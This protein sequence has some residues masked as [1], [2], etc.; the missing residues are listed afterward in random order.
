MALHTDRPGGSARNQWPGRV[1]GFDLLGDRVRVRVG[2]AVPL[3]AEITP[4]A[5]AA[6]DLREGQEVWTAVKATESC[7]LLGVIASIVGAA[8]VVRGVAV[9]VEDA[10]PVPAAF[11][12]ATRKV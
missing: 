3:V 1:V 8:G 2:G 4:A 6:L 7:A 10:V 12:A 9:A 5:V 11:T